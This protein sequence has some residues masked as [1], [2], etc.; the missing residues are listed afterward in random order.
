MAA[1]YAGESES[2]DRCTIWVA[3]AETRLTRQYHYIVELSIDAC[4]CVVVFVT[5]APSL[6]ELLPACRR[7]GR[8]TTWRALLTTLRR[9]RGKFFRHGTATICG[10]CALIATRTA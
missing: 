8:P 1:G 6:L 3:H 9:S 5:D 10:V 7:S 4:E 2:W